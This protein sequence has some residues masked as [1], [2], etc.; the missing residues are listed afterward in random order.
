MIFRVYS[1]CVAPADQVAYETG[2][3]AFNKCLGDHGYK[4]T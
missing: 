4:Y 1:D 3:K 2:V